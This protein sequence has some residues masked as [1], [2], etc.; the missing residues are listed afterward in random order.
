MTRSRLGLGK[1]CGIPVR[2]DASWLVIFVWVAWSLAASYFPGMYPSWSTEL[3][4]LMA[5]VTG[6]LF[7]ASVLLHE[8][9][10]ALIARSQGIPVKDITLFLFGGVSNIADEPGTPREELL[11]AAAGPLVSLVL[12]ALL[13][14]LRLLLRNGSQPLA[15][16]T[17]FL[18]GANLSLALFNLIPGFP[19]DG[20]RVLRAVLWG[21]RQD[22]AW[23]TR[24]ASRVG[25]AVAY[26]F[27]LS[28]MVRAFLGDW[29][30]GVWIAFVGLFLENA[31]RSA[32][33]QLTLRSLLDGHAVGEVMNRDCQTLPPQLTLDLLVGQYL[34]RG[35]GRC[36]TVGTRDNVL[37]LLTIHNVRGVPRQQWPTTHVSDVFTPLAEL[38][39]VAPETPL[40]N[41]LSE[42][43]AEGVNQLPVLE[44]GKLVGMI[45]RDSLLS[46]IRSRSELGV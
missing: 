39:V 26:I 13:G 16:L 33:L 36:F 9:G 25:Q 5:L 34:L 31:A 30:S 4:W 45:S 1:V 14:A 27:I 46:F 41:A 7:F 42:M 43:T 22:L 12:S 2:I 3:T 18:A 11:M 21:A 19:L 38:R 44:D 24:W 40:W 32:Q 10:H 8:L 6:L 23:A 29:V 35:A 17:L 20:G 15:A 28:G 37:G